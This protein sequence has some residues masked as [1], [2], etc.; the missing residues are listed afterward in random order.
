MLTITPRPLLAKVVGKVNYQLDF[1]LNRIC[2]ALV[3]N[4]A[5]AAAYNETAY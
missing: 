1:E 3:Q 4:L 5:G 2:G